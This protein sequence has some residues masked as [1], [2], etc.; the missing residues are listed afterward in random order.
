[1]RT[2]INDRRLALFPATLAGLAL[3][4]AACGDQPVD[5]AATDGAPTTGVRDASSTSAGHPQDSDAPSAAP[6]RETD[7]PVPRLV[8]ARPDG[9][10]VVQVDESGV[11][12]VAQVELDT[13]PRVV[14][15]ADDRHVYLVQSEEGLTQVLDVGS[16]AQGHGDHDHHYVREPALRPDVIEGARPVHVTNHDGRTAIFNDGDGSVDVFDIASVTAGGL[17]VDTVAA[18]SAH[19][20]VA[21]PTED[22]VL[23][24]ESSTGEALPDSLVL[25]AEDGAELDRF[26]GVCPG[27]H[28][29]AV[30]GSVI[31]FGCAE[32]VLL[33][34]GD[35]AVTVGYPEADTAGRVGSLYAAA[36]SS[37]LVGNY[38]ETSIAVID[39]DQQL[40]T[41]VDV[42][43]PYGPVTRGSRAEA[44][45]LGTDGVLR[46]FEPDDG[47]LLGQVQVMEPF[48]LPEGHGGLNPSLAVVGEHV[49]VA[50]P[51]DQRLVAVDT[52]SWSLEEEVAMDDV[53][54]GL[55][56]VNTSHHAETGHDEHD[57]HDEHDD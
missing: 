19:H 47:T 41:T 8:V 53:P 33:L 27:M 50:D 12:V 14:T 39:A 55:A 24:S 18:S 11:S 51:H 22:G 15:A 54:T 28:G 57:E 10:D 5:Q 56:A 4:L 29:E 49:F 16:Y 35:E 7:Q 32:G 17:T 21:V 2:I 36:G 30:S 37:V 46:A 40:L 45:V 42:V 31:A 20:G 6:A 52:A 3:S 9:V 43:E 25:L 34:D 23:V 48:E 38:A 1:M 26:D 13:Q 44:L